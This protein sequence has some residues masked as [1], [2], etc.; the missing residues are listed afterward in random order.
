MIG[1]VTDPVGSKDVGSAA[2][3][4]NLS[5]TGTPS[6]RVP[7]TAASPWTGIDPPG[8]AISATRTAP[9]FWLRIRTD[10]VVASTGTSP[11]CTAYSPIAVAQLP[12]LLPH[13]TRRSPM[14][15]WANR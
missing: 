3:S 1:S 10:V 7:G 14:A 9:V 6:A 12:Q 13:S 2:R 11:D 15:T 8:V 5:A 4:T